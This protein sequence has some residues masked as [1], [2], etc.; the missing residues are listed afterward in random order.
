MRLHGFFRR[1]QDKNE[2]GNVHPD[3]SSFTR[4]MPSPIHGIGVFA[5]RD[6]PKGTNIF[7][8]DRSEMIWVDRAGSSEEEREKLEDSTTTSVCWIMGDTGARKRDL[9]TLTVS[10]YI[11]EPPKG[12]E[13]NVECG[14]DYEFF[15]ARGH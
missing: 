8:D 4:L 3:T 9:I 6:I 7:K 12:G 15:A 10:W 11:N 5:I 14:G 2:E 13:P 1:L